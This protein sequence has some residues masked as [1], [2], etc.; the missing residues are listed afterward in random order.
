MLEEITMN[1]G[2]ALVLSEIMRKLLYKTVADGNG[3]K[4]VVDRDIPFR[5]RYRLNKN[6]MMFDRDAAKFDQM[7]LLA[8]A[9]YGEPTEDGKSVVI[10]DPE[11][12]KS[13]RQEISG[14]IDQEVTHSITRLDPADFELVK[15]T[16]IAISPEAMEVFI[17]YLVDDP[18]AVKPA[19]FKVNIHTAPTV[20]EQP[21][22]KKAEEPE[23][24]TAVDTAEKKGE[25]AK[26]AKKARKP[27]KTVKKEAKPDAEA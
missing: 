17:Y 1:V 15:D 12:E 22:E 9:K 18:D 20:T 25:E 5:L 4:A 26:P 23:E 2:S 11:K 24:K 21:E 10:K 8:L 27:R 19:E 7:R 3:G 14:L 13:F 16:D 6:R